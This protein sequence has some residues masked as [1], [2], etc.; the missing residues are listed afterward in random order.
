MFFTFVLLLS[1]ATVQA[2]TSFGVRGGISITTLRG[3]GYNAKPGL[4]LGGFANIPLQSS[5]SLQPELYFSTQGAKW[6]VEGKTELS[7]LNIPLLAKYRTA[8]RFFGETGPQVGFMLSAHDTF[9][10][11]KED[12]KEYLNTT[13][14]SWA[15]GAG[16]QLNSQI[17]LNLR[18]N[19]GLSKFWKDEKNSVIMVGVH[20]ALGSNGK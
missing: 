13:D 14:F 4:H 15:F 8:S 5:F 9:D 18:Y 11:E 1:M 6:E 7:Y 10:G 16:Y 2:Q 20:Y 19:L 3:D 12:V 17:S